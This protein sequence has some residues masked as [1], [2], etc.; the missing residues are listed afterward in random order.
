MLEI[1]I[2]GFRKLQLDHLVMD[3]N[4]TIA[5][6]GVL[7]SGISERLETL[8]SQLQIHVLTADTFGSATAELTDV[9]CRVAILPREHQDTGKLNYVQQL[10]PETTVCIGNG[11][12][13]RLMLKAAALGIAVLGEEGTAMQA[14]EAADVVTP[15]ILAALDLLIHPQRLIATLRS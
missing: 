6:D 5:C 8:S 15:S 12:I 7:L 11:R 4:G 9:S 3:Y 14:L 13:D 2:P 1:A 10:G